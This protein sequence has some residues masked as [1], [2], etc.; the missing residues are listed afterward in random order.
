M[1][2]TIPYHYNIWY[3][4]FAIFHMEM[5]QLGAQ[6]NVNS[7]QFEFPKQYISLWQNIHV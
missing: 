5:E 1:K 3:I 4:L 7:I 6:L 2:R